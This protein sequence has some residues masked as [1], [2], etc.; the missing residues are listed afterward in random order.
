[1]NT[2]TIPIP[3][4][5]TAWRDVALRLVLAACALF[6][7]GA[8]R[9]TVVCVPSDASLTAAIQQ[10]ED[11]PEGSTWDIRIHTGTYQ[12]SSQLVF[13]PDGDKDNKVF[14]LSGGW[15]GANNACQSQIID[16]TTT[17]VRN[18]ASTQDAIGGGFFFF[19]D[20]N[21]FEITSIHFEN[22]SNFVVDDKPCFGFDICPDTEA[23]V[24]E[25]DEFV[26]GETIQI[27]VFDA[28]RV[29][30]RN[31]LVA[32]MTPVY[33]IGSTIDFAPVGIDIGNNE[34]PPQI[35]FNTF[36]NINCEGTPG[37]VMVH[38]GGPNLALHHNIFQTTGCSDDIFIDPTYSG[39]A[40][41]PISNLFSNIGGS[42]SGNIADNGN[43]NN[44]NPL[45]VNSATGDY[46]LQNGSPAVNAGQTL[47]GMAQ[48][49]L[50]ASYYDLDG[51]FRPVGT[52][53]DI[54]AFESQVND[55]APPVLTVTNVSDDID[56]SGSLRHAIKM[57]NMQIGT[58]QRIAFNIP[59]ACPHVILLDSPLP[60]IT[61][62][63]VIDGYS[64]PG[65]QPNSPESEIGKV[66]SDAVICILLA[67][68]ASMSHAL[69]VPGG[70]PD[71][72]Q[73]TVDGLGFGSS[74]FSFSGAAIELLAGSSHFVTGSAFG[75]ALP[76]TGAA[77]GSL[78][79]GV[80]LRGT[81]HNAT[82]GGPENRARNYFGDMLNNAIVITDSTT[83]GHVIQNNYIGVTP[84]GLS[85]QANAA[86]GISATGGT[87]VTIDDNTIAAS[88]RGI[89]ISG[90]S[91]KYFT[92]TRNRIGVNA[93]GVGVAAQAN[94]VG[95]E[96]GGSTGEHVIGYGVNQ[97]LATGTFSNDIR[98][99]NTAGISVNPFAGNY[100]SIRGNRIEANGRDGT[101]LG[102]DLGGLGQ[103]D[104]D[105]GDADTGP[106]RSQNYPRIKGSAPNG[107][108][109]QVKG[110]LNSN[111]NEV[112]RIDF[113]RSPTCPKGA[114]GANATTFVGSID[115]N[116]GAIGIANFTAQVAP[117]GAPAYLTATATSS[118]NNTSEL[119]PCFAEDTIF[120]D[121]L[122]PPGL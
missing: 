60:D 104:N 61:D 24:L 85:A 56:D 7:A 57:A 122:Q 106:N 103:L 29:V 120:A 83:S 99:N 84:N 87:D 5:S 6:A 51:G 92:V 59:G 27:T 121:G 82:I 63:L 25:H 65:A 117:A 116:A 36:A 1:M 53:F 107:A 109:R 62:P 68:A 105:G 118:V 112:F 48:R 90:A 115:V 4:C 28:K 26:N 102:I 50:A 64:Q 95:I 11:A 12:L 67:P 111:A 110:V 113:F 32:K 77:L 9:A 76:T 58:A 52:H 47:I 3:Q 34:D 71:T 38:A 35:S 93:A 55:G 16:P 17:I 43:V 81:A 10:A 79:R 94:D 18:T 15:T 75:G 45:F 2:A 74:F 42:Y 37:G 91:T 23:V 20:N 49:A 78:Q 46:R 14:K 54:G 40:V 100:V 31:N 39:Q 70:E 80:L 22:F 30:F 33:F 66:G 108:T 44:F 19:G 72:T 119:A 89:L 96:I 86:D 8:A 114:T 98:N 88:N 69:E 21:R 101:G 73:L 13:S 97:N 41:T